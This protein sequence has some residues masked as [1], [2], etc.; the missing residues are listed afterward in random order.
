MK[1]KVLKASTLVNERIIGELRT[2]PMGLFTLLFLIGLCFLLFD[3]V[4][5][6]I[7]MLMMGFSAFAIF[8]AP[9]NT[10]M[11]FTEEYV[12]FYNLID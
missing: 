5:Q 6:A 4:Y 3:C 12:V 8:I 2:K 1:S 9:D 10:L 7:G 11:Q